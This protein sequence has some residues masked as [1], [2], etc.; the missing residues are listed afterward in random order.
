MLLDINF[1]CNNGENT[2]EH[3]SIESPIHTLYTFGI[4]GKDSDM[5]GILGNISEER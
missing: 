4:F 5:V 3:D 1:V 2:T